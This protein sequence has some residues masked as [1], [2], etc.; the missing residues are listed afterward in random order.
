MPSAY[1]WPGVER[2]VIAEAW[3]A[4]IESATVPHRISLPASRKPSVFRLRPPFQIP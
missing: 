2:N 1:A 3:V 4:M